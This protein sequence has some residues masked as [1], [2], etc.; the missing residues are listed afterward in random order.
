MDLSRGLGDVYKRQH[1]YIY[2]ILAVYANLIDKK[3]G[4]CYT[5]RV[6][7]KWVFNFSK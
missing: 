1:T 3:Y 4:F 6:K 2:I 5:G 7:Y